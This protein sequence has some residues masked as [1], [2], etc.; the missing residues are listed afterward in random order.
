MAGEQEVVH[1]VA[2]FQLALCNLFEQVFEHVGQVANGLNASHPGA[3]LERVDIPLQFRGNAPVRRVFG[4]GVQGAAGRVD[5]VV[6]FFQE[7]A[8]QLRIQVREIGNTV[9]HLAGFRGF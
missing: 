7:N 3:T 5:Q 8:D 6:G 2:G 9:F 1:G 4:P